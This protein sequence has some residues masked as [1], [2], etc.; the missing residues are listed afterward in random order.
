MLEGS[1]VV[2]CTLGVAHVEYAKVR[3]MHIMLNHDYAW[4]RSR[5]RLIRLAVITLDNEKQT[6]G[7]SAT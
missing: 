6:T 4:P 5:Q 1:R 3:I 7:L 2:K